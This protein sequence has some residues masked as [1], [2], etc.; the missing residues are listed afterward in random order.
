[1]ATFTDI[2]GARNLEAQFPGLEFEIPFEGVVPIQAWGTV[3]GGERFYFRWRGRNADLTVGP[4]NAIQPDTPVDLVMKLMAVTED[5]A[6]TLVSDAPPREGEIYP[7]GFNVY[8][9]TPVDDTMNEAANVFRILYL[10]YELHQRHPARFKAVPRALRSTP[11]DGLG[12]Q[13]RPRR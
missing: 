7:R 8:E 11:D 2:D 5:V 10:R 6:K 1:V 13:P 3:A 4:P 12:R 9:E